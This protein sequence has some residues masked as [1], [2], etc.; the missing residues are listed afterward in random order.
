MNN[1]SGGKIEIEFQD[2]KN[3][4][5]TGEVIRGDIIATQTAL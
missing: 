5:Q 2:G 3:N 4:Y 1:L